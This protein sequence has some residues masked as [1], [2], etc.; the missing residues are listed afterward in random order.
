MKEI[1]RA[2]RADVSLVRK[3]GTILL[4]PPHPF[5]FFFREKSSNICK[6][7]TRTFAPRVK[8]FPLFFLPPSYCLAHFLSPIFTRGL[9]LLNKEVPEWTFHIAT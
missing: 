2:D 4:Q 5:S 6:G 7:M 1:I 3:E 9:I 8:R